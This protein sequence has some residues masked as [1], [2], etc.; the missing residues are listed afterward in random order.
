MGY[1]LKNRQ[2]LAHP[3]VQVLGQCSQMLGCWQGG[4]EGYHGG[5]TCG[6]LGMVTVHGKQKADKQPEHL[7]EETLPA[8]P[9]DLCFWEDTQDLLH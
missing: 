9:K 8:S 1:S 6:M 3:F 2:T 4:S 7:S 5:G